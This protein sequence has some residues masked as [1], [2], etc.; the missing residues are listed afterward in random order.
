MGE[1]KWLCVYVCVSEGLVCCEEA[2]WIVF[3]PV[4]ALL[5]YFL[6]LEACVSES[7]RLCFGGWWWRMFCQKRISIV[8]QSGWK[9]GKKKAS[10]QTHFFKLL[11]KYRHAH[12]HTYLIDILSPHPLGVHI[13]PTLLI[14]VV[15]FGVLAGGVKYG[16][17]GWV[18]VRL[19][20]PPESAV[21]E[22]VL[23][24]HQSE[25]LY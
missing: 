2:S 20:Y 13:W 22:Y 17:V 8:L 23:R 3:L 16:L 14:L 15:P 18:V 9:W 6:W 11:S 19:V 25:C 7:M 12:T 5:D 10:I 4:Q 21:A 24:D 1:W